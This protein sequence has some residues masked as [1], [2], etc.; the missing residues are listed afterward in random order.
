MTDDQIAHAKILQT[1]DQ[2]NSL[3]SKESKDNKRAFMAFKGM[4]NLPQSRTIDQEQKKSVNTSSSIRSISP[5]SNTFKNRVGTILRTRTEETTLGSINNNSSSGNNILAGSRGKPGKSNSNE[6]SKSKKKNS[7][8]ERIHPRPKTSKGQRKEQSNSSFKNKLFKNFCNNK[9]EQKKFKNLNTNI[10]NLLSSNSQG[11]TTTFPNGFLDRP[12]SV[13]ENN[14][15]G[16]MTKITDNRD[17]VKK[18]KGGKSTRGG[19]PAPTNQNRS[20]VNTVLAVKSS[21]SG[22]IERSAS[23]ECIRTTSRF[24]HHTTQSKTRKGSAKKQRNKFN[25]NDDKN[26]PQISKS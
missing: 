8:K 12:S 22:F 7:S 19:T 5:S 17:R 25:V 10:N 9:K 26:N 14:R 15:K 2:S 1:L 20:Q 6:R 4:T 11:V 23:N 13:I 3:G 16:K 18:I 24:N 21:A